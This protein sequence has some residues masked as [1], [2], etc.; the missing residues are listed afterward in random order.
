V[1]LVLWA[2]ENRH[3]L[4]QAAAYLT[5]KHLAGER[6]R[7]FDVYKCSF[8][9]P[10]KLDVERAGHTY[11]HLFEVCNYGG[12]LEFSFRRVVDEDDERLS[13]DRYEAEVRAE[14][15]R[16]TSSV[17]RTSTSRR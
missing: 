7:C 8:S 14:R 11:P 12:G 1:Y 6:G 4:S 9:F 5:L 13:S 3:R 17:S 15:R 2:P 10:F 16:G